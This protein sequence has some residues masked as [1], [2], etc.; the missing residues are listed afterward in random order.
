VARGTTDSISC[1]GKR[2]AGIRPSRG[3]LNFPNVPAIQLHL[4][5]QL[6]LRPLHM[7]KETAHERLDLPHSLTLVPAPRVTFQFDLEM[8][9]IL[10]IRALDAVWPSLEYFAKLC[11]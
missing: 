4:S 5:G 10:L 8:S 11:I 3:L 7:L 1:S 6:A 9:P 2:R